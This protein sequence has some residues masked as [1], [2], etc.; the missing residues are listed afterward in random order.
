MW[1][2]G[3]GTSENQSSSSTPTPPPTAAPTSTAAPEEEAVRRT[4]SQTPSITVRPA[5]TEE[6]TFEAIRLQAQEA[7]RHPRTTS[8]LLPSQL[9]QQARSRSRGQSPSPS[10]RSSDVFNFPAVMDVET[11]KQ[12]I[13]AAVET[14]ASCQTANTAAIVQAAVDAAMSN[15]AQ[16]QLSLRKPSFPPFD[17]KNIEQWLRRVD[18]AFDRLNITSPKFKFAHLD[19]KLVDKDPVINDFM[20]GPA[21]Q[22]TWNSLVAYLRKKHGRTVKQMAESVIAIPSREGRCP[23]HLWSLMKEKAGTVTLDD[24]MKMQLM[25]AMPPV[26]REHLQTKIKG[27]T[28]A[29][30]ADLCDEYFDPDGRLL[31]QS[32]TVSSVNA[33]PTR[34]STSSLRNPSTVPPTTSESTAA[35]T[36]PFEQDPDPNN[37]DINAVRFRQGQKQQFKVENRGGNGRSQSRG[38]SFTNN[39]GDSNN[40]RG[41]RNENRYPADSSSSNSGGGAS[42]GGNSNGRQQKCCYYH[43]KFGEK[44][45][46]CEEGCMMY[47]KSQTAKDQA[48]R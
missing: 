3:K 4:R 43:V 5:S 33:I 10:P 16:T 11:M 41:R 8:K 15:Q 42:G 46:R 17:A 48:S 32:N 44:A 21:T 30:V 13:Q 18:A 36:T 34:L 39:R 6:E 22:A 7:A 25:K 20:A 47:A 9:V 12:L 28:G 23:S 19:E 29:E 26:V 24:I 38:R 40:N 35:F 14:T 2:T 45:T 27:K 1:P 31:E 37:G